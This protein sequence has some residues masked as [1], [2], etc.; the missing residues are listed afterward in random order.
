MPAQE[1]DSRPTP[2]R[3][4]APIVRVDPE[5]LKGLSHPIRVEIL[6][7]L[8][9]HGASTASKLAERLG[10]S[11]G[12]TS[13][14][15]RQLERHGFVQEDDRRGSG[16]ERW[17]RAARGGMSISPSDVRDD[18]VALA[19]TTAIVHQVVGQRARQLD[20]FVREGMDA[21]GGDWVESAS[22]ISSALCLTRE[23]LEGFAEEVNATIL[24]TL[25]KYRDLGDVPG[26]LR[27]LVQF[28]AFPI[29]GGPSV[30]GGESVEER[31]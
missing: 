2:G 30:D 3:D 28:N 11:S 24:A 17:W 26:A 12:L 6:D 18:P 7:Q 1:R 29:V 10:E 9:L 13:Y 5:R 27:V 8:V 22:I 25:R 19:A 15:L 16:R 14:H 20:R 4:E 31:R 23:E 21:F